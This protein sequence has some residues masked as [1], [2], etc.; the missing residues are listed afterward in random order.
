MVL[1]QDGNPFCLDGTEWTNQ[2]DAKLMTLVLRKK[3]VPGH[4]TLIASFFC[5][6]RFSF[7]ALSQRID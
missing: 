1:V 3:V 2:Q 7:R 5:P 6:N 4:S